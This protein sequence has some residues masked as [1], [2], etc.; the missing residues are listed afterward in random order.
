MGVVVRASHVELDIQVAIKFLLPQ[1]A[2]NPGVVQRFIREAQATVRLKGEHVAKVIDVGKLTDGS[3]FM[4]MEYLS[5]GDLGQVLKAHGAQPATVACDLLMQICEGMSE[6]HA[7]GIVHR[8]VKP[9]NF[10]VIRRPDG[11]PLVKI[12]DFG[13]SKIPLGGES[14]LTGTQ[15]MVGTPAYMAPEHMRAANKADQRSD[16]WSMG[17]VLYQL[18]TNRLP[19]DGE[20]Y[21]ELCLK[22][23]MEPPAPIATPLPPGLG[24][25]LLRALTKD[26]NER[27]QTVAQLAFALSP[28][29]SDPVVAKAAVD[30]CARILE[31]PRGPRAPTLAVGGVTAPLS[32][33][34]AASSRASVHPTSVAK[35]HPTSVSAGMGEMTSGFG[36]STKNS[37][38]AVYAGGA[39]LVLLLGIGLGVFA[40]GDRSSPNSTINSAAQPSSI[41]PAIE[42]GMSETDLSADATTAA[43]VLPSPPVRPIEPRA[44]PAMPEETAK[45]G[46]Q[47][48]LE[49]EVAP[50]AAPPPVRTTTRDPVLEPGVRGEVPR[51]GVQL[52]PED[53]PKKK[54]KKKS[55][56]FHSRE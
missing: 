18:L 15:S 37:R 2:A 17:V 33:P 45:T 30:R 49:G 41:A 42:D 55:D 31:A 39:G 5:G 43:P 12:L 51:G 19:F 36:L 25:V 14:Q 38:I 52:P 1:M 9:A 47:G 53:K 50:S 22:V 40:A 23:A 6:A 13:I 20:S 54:K 21:A 8:D 32:D 11:S 29:C 3:P 7:I 24:E 4:V 44:E 56:L 46:L 28:F 10:F 48:G 27:Y 26:P 34:F 16:I 35:S